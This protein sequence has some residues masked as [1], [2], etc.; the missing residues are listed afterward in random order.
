MNKHNYISLFL[1]IGVWKGYGQSIDRSITD[2][3]SIQIELE[4]V[5]RKYP[6]LIKPTFKPVPIKFNYSKKTY[7]NYLHDGLPV[8]PKIAGYQLTD[9]LREQLNF[10]KIGVGN[11]LSSRVTG[12]VQRKIAARTNLG[13]FINHLASFHGPVDESSSAVGKNKGT[14]FINNTTK[15]K[16]TLH[17]NVG[18]GLDNVY[19]YGYP[20]TIKDI[21]RDS[22]RQQ[23]TVFN[24]SLS[25]G[26]SLKNQQI[27]HITKVNTNYLKNSGLSNEYSFNISNNIYTKIDSQFTLVNKVDLFFSSFS[28]SAG[29]FYRSFMELAPSLQYDVNDFRF[30]AGISLFYQNDTLNH[31]KQLY[32]FPK[33]KANYLYQPLNMNLYASLSGNINRLSYQ[34]IINENPWIDSNLVLTNEINKYTLLF[35]VKGN[36]NKIDYQVEA[37]YGRYENQLFYIN[38]LL[39]PEQFNAVYET[40]ASGLVTLDASL[41]YEVNKSWDLSFSNTFYAY[42]LAT[43]D[44]AYGRPTNQLEFHS[45]YRLSEKIDFSLSLHHF[46]GITYIRSSDTSNQTLSSI[47]DI[48]IGGRYQLKRNWSLWLDANNLM[49]KSYSYYSNYPGKKLNVLAGVS[50]YF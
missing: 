12:L 8:V 24:G 19:F 30:E 2:T 17:G 39:S 45:S 32:V 49:N 7:D 38:N 35:G 47:L 21:K 50:L 23:F 16:L 26:N 40:K 34:K 6:K 29:D 15:S 46:S 33:L 43:L 20:T 10:L 25:L 36:Y 11:Y 18:F 13:V 44:K 31:N 37:S 4:N 28:S 5:P 42:Q 22:I 9:S 3:V 1:L 41:A 14:V 48:S 27:N